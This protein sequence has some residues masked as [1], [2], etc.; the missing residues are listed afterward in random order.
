MKLLHS[1]I[2]WSDGVTL[3][4]NGFTFSQGFE[5]YYKSIQY[6]D[7]VWDSVQRNFFTWENAQRKFNLTQ[8]KLGE[9]TLIT[10]KF[11]D[12]WR[13]LLDEDTDTIHPG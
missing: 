3:I 11:S 4:N 12:K 9:W 2:W 7:D 1:N 8:T 13:Y 10:S 6:V 5:F